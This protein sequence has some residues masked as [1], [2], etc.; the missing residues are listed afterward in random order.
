[1]H[2]FWLQGY[3][4][5]G[6]A[7]ILEVTGLKPGSFY[8]A[9][10]SKK[11]LFVDTLQHYRKCVIQQRVTRHLESPED[12]LA[13][14]EQFFYSAIEEVPRA[15]KTG[16]LLT[17]TATEMGK[18][19]AEINRAVWLGLKQIER[20]IRRRIEEAQQKGLLSG[21]KDA[22]EI[23]LQLLASFQGMCVIS[24]VAQNKT[25]LKRIAQNA[26]AVITD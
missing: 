22:H 26:L 24:R 16:C 25:Q 8:H 15:G 3:T 19:D 13:A 18:A 2:L 1:M 4:A 9:F 20:G 7:Q 17:N 11:E 5:T 23:A 10:S 12:P 6:L 14:I 21:Q